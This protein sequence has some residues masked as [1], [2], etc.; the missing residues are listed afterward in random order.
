M[1]R[2]NGAMPVEQQYLRWEV[3]RQQKRNTYWLMLKRARNEYYDLANQAP[4]DVDCSDSA[5]YYYM[6]RNY[7]VKVNLVDG[8]IDASYQIV[9]EKRHMLFL[10]KFAS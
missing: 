10:M 8:R 2:F 5:F 4:A 7:G 9:D 6:Q 1:T 3:E